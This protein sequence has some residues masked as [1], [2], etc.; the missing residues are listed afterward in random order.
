MVEKYKL[1]TEG[2]F[3]KEC[4]LEIAHKSFLKDLKIRQK[5]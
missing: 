2:E 4:F 1:L 5:S 3:V